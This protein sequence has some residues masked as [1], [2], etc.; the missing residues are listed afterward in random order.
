MHYIVAIL[1]LVFFVGYVVPNIIRYPWHTLVFLAV[2]IGLAAAMGA[3]ERLMARLKASQHPAARHY[4][5]LHRTLFAI[6]EG[7]PPYNLRRWWIARTLVQCVFYAAVFA[8]TLA[9]IVAMGF[10]FT[11]LDQA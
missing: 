10:V 6:L 11:R 9:V 5:A 2:A 1:L 4:L 7:V 8:A 3:G